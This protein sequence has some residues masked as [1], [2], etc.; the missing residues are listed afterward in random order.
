[1][2]RPFVRQLRDTFLFLCLSS[3]FNVNSDSDFLEHILS[4]IL[5][6]LTEHLF[7]SST[8]SLAKLYSFRFPMRGIK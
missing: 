5:Q 3:V 4:L 6:Q 7:Q 2:P 8:L 1:M